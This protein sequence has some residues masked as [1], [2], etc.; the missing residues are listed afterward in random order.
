MTTKKDICSVCAWRADCQKKKFS[1]SG[2][3]VRC[4]DFVRDML[5]REKEREEQQNAKKKDAGEM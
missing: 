5:L 1:V 3:D 4:P 2:R